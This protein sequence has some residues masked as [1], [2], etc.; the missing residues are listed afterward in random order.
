MGGPARGNRLLTQPTGAIPGRSRRAQRIARRMNNL[1]TRAP[2]TWRLVR[3]PMT[4]F[5]DRAAPT[6]D[7]RFA[8]DPARLE[9]LCAALDLLPHA[10]ARV[11][12]VGTGTGAAAL[13]ASDRWPEA[14][15]LG[16]D[17]AQGMVDVATEKAAGRPHVQF[18]VAD[19]G[20]LDRGT[21]YDLVIML[22]MPPF[23]EPVAALVDPGGHLAHISSRGATTPFYTPPEKLRAGFERRGLETVAV[24]AAG[25]GKYYLARRP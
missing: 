12:D 6:W 4:R 3:R 14:E 13:M 21:G 23:F 11:L 15:V 1:V 19:V 2:W 24:G 17:I 10:P 18:A 8:S 16:I 22:N 7:L 9:P 5:F 25:P 20:E